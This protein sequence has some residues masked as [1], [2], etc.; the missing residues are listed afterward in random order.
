MM[1]PLLS[2]LM[3]CVLRLEASEPAPAPNGAF[4]TI[5]DINLGKG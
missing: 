4:E 5:L 2:L 3:L 1:S